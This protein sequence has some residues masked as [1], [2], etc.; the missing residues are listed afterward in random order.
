MKKISK[1]YLQYLTIFSLMAIAIIVTLLFCKLGDFHTHLD[2]NKNVEYI[3]ANH[4]KTDIIPKTEQKK[5]YNY[6]KKNKKKEVTIK[7]VKKKRKIIETKKNIKKIANKNVIEY[8]KHRVRIVQKKALKQK[9]Q[10]NDK[11][12]VQ[13]GAFYSFEGASKEWYRIAEQNTQTFKKYDFHIEKT[14]RTGHSAVYRLKIGGFIGRA[15][16]RSF[17]SNLRKKNTDCFLVI[18]Q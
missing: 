1:K 12:L 17:C 7:T 4:S 13:L 2:S 3:Y 8:K 14:Q 16:A 11:H 9:I 18:N 6:F 5:E 15:P 10:N